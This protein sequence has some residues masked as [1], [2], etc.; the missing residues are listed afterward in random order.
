MLEVGN[1]I[2]TDAEKRTHF[3]L[4]AMMKA[5]LLI[6]TDI[7]KL[8]DH[9]VS[10]LQNQRL[11]AFNQ[12]PVYGKGAGPYKWGINPDWTFNSTFPAQY[13]SGESVNGTMVAMFNPL[14]ETTK[15]TADFSEI[16]SLEAGGCYETTEIF[17]GTSLGCKESGVEVE[18]GAHDTA[19]LL[20]GEKC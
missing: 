10:L 17:N 19:V 11:I 4:W 16:P 5:P 2:L 8:S 12:D 14:N 18:V 3:A 15:M 6:G 9:D 20:F 7:T 13:W 1:G